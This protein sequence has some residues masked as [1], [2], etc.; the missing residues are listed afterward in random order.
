MKIRSL[1]HFAELNGNQLLGG[2][3]QTLL[4]TLLVM[5]DLEGKTRHFSNYVS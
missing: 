2:L 5:E 1:E 4:G 3:D